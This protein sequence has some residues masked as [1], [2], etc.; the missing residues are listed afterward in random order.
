MRAPHYYIKQD[1]SSKS[2]IFNDGPI[3]SSGLTLRK[4]KFLNL[5]YHMNKILLT[6]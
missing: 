5:G 6:T 3:T 4:T 2:T 1:K